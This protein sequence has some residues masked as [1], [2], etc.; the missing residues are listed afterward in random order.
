MQLPRAPIEETFPINEV[1][2]I[3]EKESTGFGRRHYRP[4]YVMHKWWARRLGSVFRTILLYSLADEHI[5]GWNGDNRE[6]WSLYASDV[7]IRNRT[8]VD[9]MMG[10]G[11]TIVEALRFGHANQIIGVDI[12][13]VAWFVVKKEIEDIDPELLREALQKLEQELGDEFRRYYRTVCPECGGVANAIY[14]FHVKEIDCD[15]CG[16]KVP[17][18]RNFFLANSP[19][20]Q[21][22]VVICPKCWSMYETENADQESSCPTCETLFVP[23]SRSF[24]SGR[25]YE[26]SS[27]GCTGGNV[28]DVIQKQGRPRERLYAVEFYC[29]ECDKNQNPKLKR[30]RGYKSVGSYDVDLFH[31]AEQEFKRERD[32]L[33]IPSTKIPLGVETQRALKHGYIR[34]SD[35]FN[36]RQLLNLGKIYRWI[37]QIRNQNLKE[38]L[39]LAFSNCLKYNN[40]F[41]KYNASNGFITDIFRT[42]SF[43]PSMTPVEANCYDPPKGR[44]SF[45]NFVHLVIEGKKYCQRPFERLVENGESRKIELK[46][47]ILART[48]FNYDDLDGNA[49]TCLLCES[50]QDLEISSKTVDLVATDPPYYDNVAYSELSN[51]F[52]AWLRMSL[53]E[54]YEYFKPDLV[55]WKEEIVQNR[56][57]QKSQA[58]FLDGIRS[59]FAEANRILKDDG[60]LVFTFHHKELDAWTALVTAVLDAGF[61]V[62]QSWPIRSEMRA[63]THLLNVSNIKYDAIIV[64]RKRRGQVEQA[65]WNDIK[66]KIS[67]TIR[68]SIEELNRL[69]SDPDTPDIFV[70]ALGKCFQLYSKHYPN[71][72]MG[73]R[74]VSVS[75]AL[76]WIVSEMKTVR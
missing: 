31:K 68:H 40:S 32:S 65:E 35:M 22:D 30:G 21:G 26:C 50:S 55:P 9:P 74:K 61:F 69:G 39:L 17:L 28:I 34:F 71:V 19:T 24:V 43:S 62:S 23:K 45:T 47:P 20:D 53:A 15:K 18:M 37:L 59:V 54:E 70:L 75:E 46:N 41:C 25:K 38:F 29:P 66:Q 13:P 51:F 5:E 73:D 2:K 44:G 60:L 48:C 42:H 33:P 14:Y 52:Y 10:G 76:E 63:S 11:T 56:I 27:E 3:A 1:N 16:T 57:Q 49:N 12:N 7:E 67:R 36:K 6:L 8:I 58:E 4:V 72:M 64:C